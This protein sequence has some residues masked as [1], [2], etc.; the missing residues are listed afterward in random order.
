M[1]ETKGNEHIRKAPFERPTA[2]DLLASSNRQRVDDEAHLPHVG[3]PESENAMAGDLDDAEWLNMALEKILKMTDGQE[4]SHQG[5]DDVNDL[6]TSSLD[7]NQNSASIPANPLD[8]PYSEKN[9]FQQPMPHDELPDSFKPVIHY[10]LNGTLNNQ[11]EEQP[12]PDITDDIGEPE[13]Q[14]LPDM[15]DD[16]DEPEEQ[17]LPDMT[18]DFDEPEE[19][20]LPDIADDFDEP[21]EQPLP[22][23]A[24]DFDEPEEEPLPDIADDFDEPEEQPL[25][26]IAD[27]FDEPEEEPLPD[28]TDDF[29][30]PEEQ[31]LPDVTDFF[32]EPEEQ[33]LPDVTDFFDEPEEQPL[34]DIADDFDEPE[35]QPLPD[36]ADYFDEPEEQP[37]QDIADFDETGEQPLPDIADYFDEPEEQPLPDM[38]DYFDEPEE[39]PLF[40]E[41]EEEPL[42]DE[43]EEQ[44]LLDIADDFDEPEEQ[45][46]PDNS[47]SPKDTTDKSVDNTKSN[48][49]KQDISGTFEQSTV[50]VSDGFSPPSLETSGILDGKSKSNEVSDKMENNSN[51]SK[52]SKKSVKTKKTD[53]SRASQK[54]SKTHADLQNTNS[55]TIVVNLRDILGYIFKNILIVIL[56]A[57]MCSMI[58][59]IFTQKFVKHKYVSNTKLIIFTA[60]AN[61]ES[62]PSW[63]DLQ[64]SFTLLTDCS[65]IVK[66]RDV[67][68][69]VIQELD[70]SISYSE[71]LE[72]IDVSFM[73]NSR[74]IEIS[75]T[76]EDP[77]QAMIIVKKLREVSMRYIT[78]NLEVSG[79]KIIQKENIPHNPMPSYTR[80]YVMFGAIIGILVSSLVLA[81]IYIFQLENE[82]LKK[83]Q[84]ANA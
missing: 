52:T 67:L 6:L 18:D 46:L 40:D 27:D 3:E 29:D 37:L 9:I 14:P 43:P 75:V 33:P 60:E 1:S 22:D 79:S 50:S 7:D 45:P 35:E 24:D 2:A 20:P 38:T 49:A 58:G 65:L 74:I 66:S 78:D 82:F 23:M 13:E 39:E 73:S 47:T 80:Y 83:Q 72:K 34:P 26:D 77:L 44:P 69:D 28:M 17:P 55:S 48:D 25:P 54:I 31:P 15:A 30:E 32:D 56:T 16:F 4:E 76:D 8:L 63:D 36:I 51:L 81:G 19:Q 12:L 84:K 53:V 68:E 10:E 71:L 62:Q 21:E 70:L 61:N 64:L 59:Y 42:F 11:P 41:P 57:L 5:D